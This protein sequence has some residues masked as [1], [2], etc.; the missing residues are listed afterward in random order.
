MRWVSRVVPFL[1][2]WLPGCSSGPTERAARPPDVILIV[3]DTLRADH[4]HCYGYARPTSPAI[5]A[6]ALVATRYALA[7]STA[8]WTLPSHASMFTG[9]L[10]QEHGAV[11][12]IPERPDAYDANP[13]SEVIPTLAE[14]LRS[15]GY[16]TGG[17]VSNA[18]YCDTWTGLDRGFDAYQVE[19]A[20]A[21][22][23]LPRAAEWLAAQPDRPAFVLI[24]LIDVHTPYNTTKPAG[25]LNPPASTQP[26]LARRL[27]AQALAR[28]RVTAR[29]KQAVIDQYDTAIANA[30]Q[31]IGLFFER[32]RAAGRF[33]SSV[34]VVTSDHGEGFGEHGLVGHS[35]DVYETEIHVPLMI[36]APRQPGGRV[37]AERISLAEL[38]RMIGSAAGLSG[39]LLDPRGQQAVVIAQNRYTRAKN[40]L[41]N[42]DPQRL[43]RI[44]TAIYDTELKLI[45]SSDGKHEL[46]DL[47]RDP[48]E[49]ENLA[50]QRPGDVARLLSRLAAL[51]AGWKAPASRPPQTPM[52]EA[53]RKSMQALGYL[54][55]PESEP[56]SSP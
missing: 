49:L 35:K 47:A 29:L 26:E 4:L 27:S 39:G 54:A 38:P 5:D 21:D 31:Q 17:F 10:P 7:T 22:L 8:P 30:D 20:Y 24:N 19:N 15:R 34:I 11:T 28:G 32:M 37:V 51:E 45:R 2:A 13:L 50:G 36:K 44:R 42:P 56:A 43:R 25:F 14:V 48:L 3:I 9:L 23:T 33:D 6:F 53:Q 52:T 55:G 40:L 16:R 12:I 18:V 41:N 1:F 46:Y